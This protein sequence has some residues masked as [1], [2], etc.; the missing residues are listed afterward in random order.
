MASI[1][2]GASGNGWKLR[3]DYTVTQD[4]AANT[5]SLRL[6]LYLYANTTGVIQSGEG[7]GVLRFAGTEGLSDVSVHGA[8]VVSAGRADGDGAPW[9]G[10]KRLGAAGRSVGVG[11]GIQLDPG[12]PVGVGGG[13]AAPYPAALGAAGGG[14]DAGAGVC[15]D[16][17]CRGEAVHPPGDVCA[18]RRQRH[19]GAGDGA[20]GADV[21]AAAGAGPAAAL[22]LWRGPCV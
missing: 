21:D 15:A 16:H 5:S 22:N 1:Y 4:R 10:R 14:T 8:G 3:L 13:S 2:G 9:G 11:C 12:Q 17:S 7:L 6:R 20:A 18:G 19:G